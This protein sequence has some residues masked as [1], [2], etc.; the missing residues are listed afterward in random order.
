M[1][2]FGIYRLTKVQG[3]LEEIVSHDQ[4]A[5]EM[6]F[7]MQEAARDRSVLLFSIVAASD[8]FERDELMLRHGRLGGQ[9][10]QARQRLCLLTLNRDER[11][12]LEQVNV[13]VTTTQNLQ[14]QVIDKV[15]AEHFRE[16]NEMLSK[17]AL[18]AQSKILSSINAMLDYEIRQSHGYQEFLQKRQLQ[19][20]FFMVADFS[21]SRVLLVS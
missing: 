7:R 9:F 8:P 1:F 6:L 15:T 16:A 4:V 19:D 14:G 3:S 2:F 20:R 21:D 11:A 13:H 12:L 17:Y 18:P 10:A 5:I